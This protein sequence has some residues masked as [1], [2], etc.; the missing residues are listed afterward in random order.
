MPREEL[1]GVRDEVGVRLTRQ[2][3][4]SAQGVGHWCVV[5]DVPEGECEQNAYG[6]HL[7]GGG[8][9]GVTKAIGGRGDGWRHS[10]LSHQIYSG[11]IALA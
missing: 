6:C 4:E 2:K 9:R 5:V 1:F 3:R 11:P 7:D 8:F 10:G